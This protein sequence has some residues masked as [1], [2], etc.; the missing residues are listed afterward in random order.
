ME[1]LQPPYFLLNFL[2]P[3]LRDKM[4]YYIPESVPYKGASEICVECPSHGPGNREDHGPSNRFLPKPFFTNNPPNLLVKL[5]LKLW[6][7]LIAVLVF[8]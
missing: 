6:R 4:Q 1:C 5:P 2:Y 7:L 8:N 3:I